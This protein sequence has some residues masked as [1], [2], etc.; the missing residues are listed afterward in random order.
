MTPASTPSKI[1]IVRVL[2]IISDNQKRDIP[3]DIAT[4]VGILALRIRTPYFK[5]VDHQCSRIIQVLHEFTS[6]CLMTS[7]NILIPDPENRKSL[8]HISTQT[9]A[10]TNN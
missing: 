4:S 1:P 6:Q 3:F 8:Y 2:T 5:R 7:P 10:K 9:K